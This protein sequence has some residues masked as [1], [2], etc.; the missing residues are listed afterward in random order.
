MSVGGSTAQGAPIASL[1]GGRPS[2]SFEFFPPRSEEAAATLRTTVTELA[3]LSPSFVSVTY[4]AG[5]STRELTHRLVVDLLADGMNPMA[6]LTAV[7]H[8]RDELVDIVANYRDA[9]VRNVLA[10]RG[11][12]P[13]GA[14]EPLR[15]LEHAIDLVLLVREVA[16]DTA[17]VGVAAHPEGHPA[18]P[19]LAQDRQHLAAKLEA[20]DF[21]VTQFFFEAADHLRMVEDL[22]A[23]GCTKP[24]LP[25]IMPVTNL[26]QIERFAQL[27]GATFPTWLAQRLTAVGDDPVAV[28]AVGVEVATELCQ[29]LLDA[30]VPGL[31]FYTL[32]RS[33]ATREIA[34]NLGLDAA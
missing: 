2:V 23:L 27:S 18:S 7:E 28:R 9:G 8:T 24:V 22:A 11:D 21:A 4:G 20:A 3:P 17:S 13:A 15:A 12:A 25:G 5:G 32:N 16:G 26:A 10:L 34:A 33:T 29:E 1:L 19:S 14:E 6:H 30:G 31:H